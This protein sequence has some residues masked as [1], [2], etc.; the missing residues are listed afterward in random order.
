VCACVYVHTSLCG[1]VCACIVRNGLEK[2]K[3]LPLLPIKEAIK[4]SRLTVT[5]H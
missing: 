4:G 3:Q 5:V 1:F 2:R